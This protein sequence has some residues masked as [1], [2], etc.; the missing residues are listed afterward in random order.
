A[1]SVP[2][3]ETSRDPTHLKAFLDGFPRRYLA[4]H[5][6]SEIGEHFE[7]AQKISRQPVQ[8]KVRRRGTFSEITVL[9][10]DRPFLFAS[11][12]G[13]L[14]AWGMNILKAEALANSSGIVLDVFR[15]HD[16]HRT[17]EMNPSEIK[18]LEESVV[19]VLSGN[20]SV[21]TLMKGRISTQSSLG[22]KI[23]IGTQVS[24]DD[25]SSSR[26]TI[27][28]VIAQD[29]PGLLYRVSDTLAE[30]AC[31]IE[32]ALIETEAQKVVDIF[33]LTQQGAK[34]NPDLQNA[35]RAALIERLAKP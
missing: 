32:V 13:T 5:S 11:I 8:A 28:E 3:L 1:H 30:F 10:A 21:A 25:A 27:L 7:W 4:A 18:R 2:A 22:A 15:F 31:N 19:E 24:F 20:K 23:K 26:C 17:L 34:L 6:P 33:Y 29:R 16:L 14:A 35:I 12:A 9:A